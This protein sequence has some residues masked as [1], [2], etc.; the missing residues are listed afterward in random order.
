VTERSEVTVG[1]AGA[2]P[3]AGRFWQ[4]RTSRSEVAGVTER[5]EVTVG[6]AGADPLA[7]RFWQ[8]RTSRSE[9]RA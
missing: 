1:L 4:A 3:L 7:G 2:D 9:V 5:S 6:L 8:A